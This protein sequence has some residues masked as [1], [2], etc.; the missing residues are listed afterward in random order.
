MFPEFFKRIS[1]SIF[2]AMVAVKR[3]FFFF[4]LDNRL[5][6]QLPSNESLT[7][8]KLAVLFIKFIL[9]LC[10]NKIL[11]SGYLDVSSK[12]S[13]IDVNSVPP[14]PGFWLVFEIDRLTGFSKNTG[15]TNSKAFFFHI[16]H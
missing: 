3:K 9:P 6:S 16:F 8:L 7:N 15:I 11:M 2:W 4:W 5:S 10:T 1:L 14:I 12:A 13:F